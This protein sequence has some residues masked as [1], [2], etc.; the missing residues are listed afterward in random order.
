MDKNEITF[1]H[2]HAFDDLTAL[3][4]LFVWELRRI[5]KISFSFRLFNPQY[6]PWDL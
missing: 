3:K 2:E 4:W 1:V 6:H 5:T